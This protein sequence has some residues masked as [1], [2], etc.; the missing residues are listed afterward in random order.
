MYRQHAEVPSPGVASFIG[1]AAE[2]QIARLDSAGAS[3]LH[4]SPFLVLIQGTQGIGVFWLHRH[5]L[6]HFVGQ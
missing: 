1:L 4:T 2:A 3:T 5:L 6:D